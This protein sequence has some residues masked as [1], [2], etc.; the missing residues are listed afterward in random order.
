MKQQEVQYQRFETLIALARRDPELQV[1]RQGR[2][3]EALSNPY[4]MNLPGL[5]PGGGGWRPPMSEALERRKRAHGK[6]S[7][8]PVSTTCFFASIKCGVLLR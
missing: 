8:N 1:R 7:S 3:A 4:V 2:K 6:R 5:G